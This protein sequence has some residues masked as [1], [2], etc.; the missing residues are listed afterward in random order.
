MLFV[1]RN[2]EYW[3]PLAVLPFMVVACLWLWFA[4][5][6]SYAGCVEVQGKNGVWDLRDFDFSRYDAIIVGEVE[7]IPGALLTP[8]EFANR[9]DEILVG[10]A[11]AEPFC[12][13]RIRILLPDGATY[14]VAGV[15]VDYADRFYL[16]GKWMTDVGMP[17]E[18][19]EDF[20][21]N[22]ASIAFMDEPVDGVLTVVQQGANYVHRDGGGHD[23]WRVGYPDMV[24]TAYNNSVP[25]LLMGCYFV[26][27]LVQLALFFIRRGYRPSLYGALFCLVWFFRSGVI[28][29]KVFSSFF[30]NLSWYIKF[31]VEY[32]SLPLAAA[33]VV[34]AW[35]EFFPHIFPRWFRWAV[36]AFSAAFSAFFVLAPPLWMS[37]AMLGCYAFLGVGIVLLLAFLCVKLRHPTVEQVVAVLG[38]L[39]LF[40]AAIRDMFYYNDIVLP[41]FFGSDFSQIAMLLFVLFEMTAVVMGTIREAETAKVREAAAHAEMGNLR[42]ETEKWQALYAQIPPGQ[43]LVLGPLALDILTQ[44]AYLNGRDLL[45]TPKEFAL[46]RYMAEHEGEVVNAGALFQE[47]WSIHATEDRGIVRTTVYRLR[48]KLEGSGFTIV[49]SRGKGYLFSSVLD[50]DDF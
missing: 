3:M 35:N 19:A 31:R 37:W 42:R 12:T 18:N 43:A 22:T 32:L 4:M 13:S 45:L 10:T 41:P 15:S 30:P 36:Y 5:S 8:E 7:Y 38:A 6:T 34:L 24:H 1:K 39:P 11:G 47:V 29:P 44:R 16:N 48:K 26:L 40:Y 21:P 9:S 33:L 28:G 46:L 2:K 25:M 23:N 50:L 49:A 14:M 17:A 27:F 20:V